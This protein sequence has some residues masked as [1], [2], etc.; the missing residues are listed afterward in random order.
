MKPASVTT[1][2]W[3]KYNTYLLIEHFIGKK[4]SE[5]YLRPGKMKLF[6]EAMNNPGFRERALHLDIKDIEYHS[7]DEI[8]DKKEI[9]LQTPLV[10]RGAAK[11]WSSVKNWS[12]DFFR[13][14]YGATPVTIIN[15]PG[16]I[17]KDKNNEFKQTNFAEYFKEA[18]KDK[19]KYLRFSRVLDNNPVLLKDLDL[20]W[21]RQF[22]S[23]LSMGDQTFLFIGE[24]DTKTPMHC[25]ISHTL[26]IQIKGKKRWI[27]CAPNERFLTDPIADRMLYF[28][29]NADINNPNDPKYPLIPYVK[30]YDIVLDEGDVLW[31]PSFFWHH[32]ENLTPTIGAAFKYQNVPESWKISKMMVLLNFMATKPTI[33][34]SVIYNRLYKQ[35]YTYNTKSSEFQ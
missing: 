11:E 21:L 28:Y 6:N 3:L 34:W 7:F 30:K 13:D 14:H 8:K 27:V 25:A 1:S 23:K 32:V 4:M 5:K 31:L 10:F 26:F 15:N 2:Q 35:D 19:S 20:D 29:T 12:K 22:K 9:L 16:L 24:N 18:E 33:I 17:E